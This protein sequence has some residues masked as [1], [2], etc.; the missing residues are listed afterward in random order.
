M[1]GLGHAPLIR[2]YPIRNVIDLDITSYFFYIR[3][4]LGH[5]PDIYTNEQRAAAAAAAQ[6]YL[7]DRIEF[8][9]INE[10]SSALN[11][12]NADGRAMQIIG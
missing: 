8:Y 1:L 2:H 4:S 12:F 10:V 3:D 9:G 6:D 7:D 11:R 5:G